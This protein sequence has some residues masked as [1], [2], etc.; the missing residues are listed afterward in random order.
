MLNLR[1]RAAKIISDGL[2]TEQIEKGLEFVKTEKEI[3]DMI[4]NKIKNVENLC[5]EVEGTMKSLKEM[6][7]SEPDEERSYYMGNYADE[8]KEY[9]DYKIYSLDYSKVDGEKEPVLSNLSINSKPKTTSLENL[10]RKYNQAAYRYY[11]LM[12]KKVRLKKIKDNLNPK[13]KREQK[14]S[15]Y[16]IKEYGF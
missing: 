16:D 5:A 12:E 3:Y 15:E 9:E 4:S 7:G 14:L 10:K 1:N 8:G 11:N 6:I 2:K 13:S